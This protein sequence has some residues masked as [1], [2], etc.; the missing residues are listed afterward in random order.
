MA[1]IHGLCK[2]E[3]DHV[4]R[5][6]Q[7]R[8]AQG[9]E[10]GASLCVDIKG[11]T[12]IDLWGGHADPAKTRPW[13]E[14]T[15]TVVWSCSKVVCALAAAI[16]IDRGVLDPDEKVS[17]YWPEFAANGKESI[18]VA[19]VLSHTSG[20]PSWEPPITF[21]EICDTPKSTE[22]L[23][24]QA[25]WWTPGQS[26]GY[27]LVTHGHLIGELVRRT[28]GK[29]LKQFITEEIAEPLGADFRLGLEQKDWSRTADITPP[30]PMALDR[31]SPE[32]VACRA[33]IGG[34]IE[35]E[36]SMSLE[37]RNAEIGASNGFGNARS[38][39]RIGSVISLGGTRDGKTYLSQETVEQMI[40]ERING[41]DLVL[42][43][44]LRFGLGVGLPAPETISGIPQGRVCFWGG[45]G[46]STIIMDLDRQMTIG[47][48]M[49]KM[50]SGTLGNA[51]T[52]A[53]VEEIYRAL[54]R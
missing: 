51:N 17:K 37:F 10:L 3:F 20:L 24:Q 46:G 52:G 49:N 27:H 53:Y 33:F 9:E 4:R 1:E 41:Q 40:Q 6:F 34:V 25:P 12:V 18:T 21:Q 26:S 32:S 16:L 42:G 14:D 5:I 43:K 39:C 8:I 15:L 38:L 22:K 54:D 19:H 35:A 30:P 11:E 36:E 48:A 47:Y 2:P 23:A 44:S 31:L 28:T 29:S 45:W 13:E 7:E 50:A